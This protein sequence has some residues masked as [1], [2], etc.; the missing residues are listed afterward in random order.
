M[1]SQLKKERRLLIQ[2]VISGSPCFVL[3]TCHHLIH[4][5][6]L[7]ILAG[8]L[9]VGID[10][11][12]YMW[13]NKDIRS[14]LLEL[15]GYTNYAGRFHSSGQVFPQRQSSQQTGTHA[16]TLYTIPS[17]M[18]PPNAERNDAQ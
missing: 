16:Q 18:P 15:I 3:M 13:F 7:E 10:P 8:E 9:C 6:F 12:V 2:A 11:V 1:T 4:F 5:P 17:E 14:D